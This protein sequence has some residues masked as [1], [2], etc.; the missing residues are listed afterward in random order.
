[1]NF[2]TLKFEA[3]DQIGVLTIFR[4]KALNALNAQVL[5]ELGQFFEALNSK[6]DLRCLILTGSGDKAFVAGADIKALA[7]IDRN[8]G[9]EFA[10]K[11]QQVFQAIED[12]PIPV[13]AAVNGFALGGGLELAMACDFIIASEKAKFGLPEVSLGI[14]PCYGGTQR[15]SRY[16]GKAKARMVI[17]TGEIYSAQEAKDWGL[18]AEVVVA[19]KL[20][21][22]CM[23]IA[24][25]ISKRSPLAVRLARRAVTDGF[26]LSQ[27]E[28]LYLEA[29]LFAQ[30]FSSE[31]KTEGVN[32]FIEKREPKFTGK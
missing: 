4:P 20:Q 21:E 23:D 30:A 18:V 16:I 15:L 1:M 7:A 6:T 19:E 14:I 27:A 29:E 9:T 22:K 10:Q 17:A 12:S 25:A 2:E 5:S 13:I 26:E 24:A 3:K 28:G 32:A 11:G 31:D 8:S